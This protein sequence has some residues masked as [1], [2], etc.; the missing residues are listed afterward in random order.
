LN[1][2]LPPIRIRA[3]GIKCGTMTTTKPGKHNFYIS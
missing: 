2:E 1:V 3:Y